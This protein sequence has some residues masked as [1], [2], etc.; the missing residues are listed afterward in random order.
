[1]TK[2]FFNTKPITST[3]RLHSSPWLQCSEDK[4]FSEYIINS[5]FIEAMRTLFKPIEI[6]LVE[7][8]IGDI[9]LTKEAFA[10]SNLDFRFD[11]VRD[12]V[13]ALTYLTKETPYH[14]ASTPDLILLDLNMP[15]KSGLEV[16][17]EIKQDNRLKNI[18]IVIMTGSQ[19]PEDKLICYALGANLYVNKPFGLDEFTDFV[20]SIENFWLTSLSCCYA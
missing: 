2:F 19:A 15:R 3:E 20:K 10:E 5:I 14:S 8:D 17:E 1:M 12:G 7:D 11:I 6:L 4:I 18:P 16:L 13:E 9:D